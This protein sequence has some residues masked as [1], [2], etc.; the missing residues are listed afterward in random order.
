[1]SRS[2]QII[3]VSVVGIV[4]NV[5]L[6]GFKALVGIL[7]SS[8]AIVLDAVN[9]LSDALSSVITIIG[10]KLSER[11]A[12][13]KHP[14]GYG[15][16]EYFTAIIIAVI[17]L[18]TGITSLVESVDK[19]LHPSVPTYTTVTLVVII[20]AIVGKLLLG[21]Y[22]RSQGKKLGSGALIAS[23]SDALF[24]AVITLATLVSAGIMLLWNVSLDGYLGAL[25]SIVII[26]AGIEMLAA[27]INQLLG[28]QASPELVHMIK[29][30]VGAVPG[31][32]GVFDIILHGYG[33]NLSIGSLHVSVADTMNAHQI[34]RLTR[35]IAEKMLLN[36]GIVMTVGIYACATGDNE[37]A[38][39]QKEVVQILTHQEHVLQVHGFLFHEE[40][41]T[42]SVDVVPDLTIR[43]E[44]AFTQYL[45]AKLK[46]ALPDVP[47]S[48]V[49]DHNYSD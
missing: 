44:A 38:Q 35:E 20:S 46:E 36:H 5:L 40:N 32:Q 26:K 18:V 21:W 3:R 34:H 11:P 23:G 1:M 14:F 49:L 24:D 48:I 30:E 10:T 37:R 12:D 8:V 15:R 19:I 16:V 28:A 22:V 17:V 9:N 25:I 27:P 13:R 33:P 45:L 43:D 47:V 2:K 7:A 31:V 41:G 42:V 4:A 39:L 29:T 6:A